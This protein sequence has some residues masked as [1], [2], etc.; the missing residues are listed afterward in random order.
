MR[1]TDPTGHCIWDWCIVE[2]ALA[3]AIVGIGMA[4]DPADVFAPDD[5]LAA[6]PPALNPGYHPVEPLRDFQNGAYGMAVAGT[7]LEVTPFDEI[8]GVQR[9]TRNLAQSARGYFAD[10][11]TISVDIQKKRGRVAFDSAYLN[12]LA[13]NIE[14]GWIDSDDVFTFHHPNSNNVWGLM[15]AGREMNGAMT[16]DI[17]TG[18][19]EG[20]NAGTRLLQ[21]AVLESQK[22][23]YKGKLILEPAPDS[24]SWYMERGGVRTD[25]YGNPSDTG[26]YLFWDEDASQKLLTD[27]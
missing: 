14:R 11:I 4:V 20:T 26:H 10:F 24:M 21:Q 17:L 12:S 13:K 27:W 7:L 9:L 15:V 16:I 5:Q 23:G 18:L 2:I 25:M 1:Y 19:G 3:V 8:P 6:N 22:R